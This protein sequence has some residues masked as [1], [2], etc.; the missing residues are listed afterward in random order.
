MKRS[1]LYRIALVFLCALPLAAQNEDQPDVQNDD[2]TERILS[3]DSL[4]TVHD[5]GSMLVRETIKVRSAG[6]Q[7]KHGIYRDFPT[8]YVSK[9]LRLRDSRPFAIVSVRRDGSAESYHTEDR[10]GGPRIYFGS[11]GYLLP[12]G[13]HTYELT[14][15]TDRQLRFF[16]DHDELYWNVNGN[17]WQFPIDQVTAT[18]LLPSQ[19]R[20]LVTELNGYTGYE[21]EKGRAYTASRDRESNPVFRAA[22]LAAQQNLSISI[23]WPKGLIEQPTSRQKWDWFVTDN[24][25]IVVGAV[26][27]AVILIY[28]LSVWTMVGRDPAPGTL[29]PLYEPQ[30]NMSPAGMRYLEH[31]G[32]DNK[33]FTAGILGLAARGYLKI[34]MDASKTYRLVRQPGYGPLESQLPPDEK[35]LA[36]KLFES[37]AKLYLSRE[38]HAVLERAKKTLELS[39]QGTM[40]K[41]Y[42]LTNARYLWPGLALTALTAIVVLLSGS[43]SALALGLFMSVWL[44]GWTV[45]VCG[46]L[47]QVV[48]AWKGV[49]GQGVLAIPG[50]VVISAFSV[51]FLAGEGLGIY[52]LWSGGGTAIVAVVFLGIAINILF[53]YLLKA[54]TRQG[55][56]LMDRVEGFTMFLKAVDGDRMTLMGAPIKT[57]ELFERFLPYAVAMGVEHA[58]ANQFSQVLAAA[59]GAQQGS[60]GYSPSWYS[61]AG[62]GSFTAASFASSF[63]D[64]FS[65]AVSSASAPVSSSSG[66]G[67]GGG[68]SSGGGGGGGGGGGW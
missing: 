45:G 28:F 68:G 67:S 7:I 13:I 43:G 8:E 66:S 5:D 40:E 2:Q 3:F 47:F 24:K 25:G 9:F 34:E 54:P 64:S 49:R 15:S 6:E 62:V 1:L 16:P 38:N 42:F 23:S 44:S 12:P 36:G 4:I 33:V 60:S 51:P 41:T 46:L 14:Y 21:G 27:L 56:Q 53:H 29:V 57:P 22:N 37:G 48:H 18:V 11:A 20:N 17:Q 10:G 31:M 55:R 52:M 39:L 59:A 61:G 35:L 19:L 65:S 50:A 26:G 32:F 30:D 63:S 58:W